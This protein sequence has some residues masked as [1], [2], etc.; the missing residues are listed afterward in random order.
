M[1]NA[2]DSTVK[3]RSYAA[4]KMSWQM[5]NW[6]SDQMLRRKTKDQAGLAESLEEGTGWLYW[7][8][9]DCRA[10]VD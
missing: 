8:T 5:Q 2:K 1:L 10:M 9:E 7:S 4:S 3:L 6:F